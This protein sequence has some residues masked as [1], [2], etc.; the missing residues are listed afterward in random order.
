MII[1]I[2]INTFVNITKMKIK[3]VSIVFFILI[4]LSIFAPHV[5]AVA[6]NESEV[7]GSYGIFFNSFFIILREGFEAILIISALTAYLT[8]SGNADK[9][10]TVYK[11][12][13]WALLASIIT[14]VL[15]Q[16]VFPV[17]ETGKEAVEGLTML[18]A[19]AVLFYVSYWL[20]TKSEVTRWQGYIK[21]KVEMSIGKGSVLALGFAS[22]IAVYREGAETAL[23]YLAIYSTSSG[24]MGP[25]V[26]G[27]LT[28]SFLLAII[29][30][31]FRYGSVKI[32]IG[33][34][35]AVTSTLLYYLAFVFAGKG[36]HELQEAGWIS[37]T[38]LDVVPRVEFL[39]LYPTLEGL[40]LQA[41]L[42][43]AM[44]VAVIYGMLIKPYKEKVT[45]E[46]DISNIGIDIDNL[47]EQDARRKPRLVGGVKAC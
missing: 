17:G 10:K 38:S 13:L 45:I 34:F 27:M 21:S 28:G 46:K 40:T 33:P 19:T 5:Q 29:F 24:N 36:I 9:V 12:A 8:R 42:I 26:A 7:G 15:L 2:N 43:G 4:I 1:I 16:R 35:F 11:G 32:P 20:I 6:A 31:L 41:L 44:M 14:A 22:F 47:H 18:L 25:I 30:F 39:G 23:F 3:R 37:E